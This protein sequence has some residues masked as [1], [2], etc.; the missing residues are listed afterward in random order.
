MTRERPQEAEKRPFMTKI[1]GFAVRERHF[2]VFASAAGHFR[3]R[4][5]FKNF[6]PVVPSHPSF[7]HLPP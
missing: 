6:P 4:M 2:G 5:P 7:V 3:V 1:A